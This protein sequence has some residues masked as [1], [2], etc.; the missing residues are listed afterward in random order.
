[1]DGNYSRKWAKRLQRADT[2]IFLGSP[3]WLRLWRVLSRTIRGFRRTRPDLARGCPE[4][5]DLGF[6]FGWVLQFHRRERPEALSL[7]TSDGSLVA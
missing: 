4:R 6:I 3:V 5:L 7:M 1:M 2:V